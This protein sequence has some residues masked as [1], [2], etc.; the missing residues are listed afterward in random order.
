MQD[1]RLLD[2]EV[3][4][5]LENVGGEPLAG[6]GFESEQPESGFTPNVG[7]EE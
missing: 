2:E 3:E 1:L 6:S 4:S 7:E 5:Q